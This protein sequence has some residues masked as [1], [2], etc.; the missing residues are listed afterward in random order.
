MTNDDPIITESMISEYSK[1]ES[2][3]RW[4]YNLLGVIASTE[5]IFFE[6]MNRQIRQDTLRLAADCPHAFANPVLAQ[7][8]AKVL[9][10]ACVRSHF[11]GIRKYEGSLAN[12]FNMYRFANEPPTKSNEP[13]L[14]GPTMT[15]EVDRSDLDL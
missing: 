6:F 12:T 14:D 8:V 11:F 10:R 1:K 7:E 2:D 13:P 15:G 4:Y 3:P 5:P 9:T